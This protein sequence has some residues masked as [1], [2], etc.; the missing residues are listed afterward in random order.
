MASVN[1]VRKRTVRV[2]PALKLQFDYW[3]LLIMAGYLAIREVNAK[4]LAIEA[5]EPALEGE[6]EVETRA[7]RVKVATVFERFRKGSTSSGSG[8]GLTISRDLVEAHG[9]TITLESV[10]GAGTTVRVT[11]PRVPA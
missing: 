3:L 10:P 2:H 4:S 9:G 6:Y 5:F 8:L 1:V 11:L 7:G